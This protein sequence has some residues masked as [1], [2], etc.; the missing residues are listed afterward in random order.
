MVPLPA[1]VFYVLDPCEAVQENMYQPEFAEL[2]G[3]AR[4]YDKIGT[5]YASQH[6]QDLNAATNG[7]LDRPYNSA[8][9]LGIDGVE[10]MH[11]VQ[12]ATLLGFM[13]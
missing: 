12:H 13:R 9:D 10:L 5:W 2:R 8:Y 3:T 11:S 7:E 6:Y 1:Q 4:T